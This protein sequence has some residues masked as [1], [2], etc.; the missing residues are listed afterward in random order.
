MAPRAAKLH[1]TIETAPD[2][3]TTKSQRK[4][5]ETGRYLLQVD[6]QTKGSYDTTESAQAA[7]LTIK[8]GHPV[9]QVSVYDTVECRNA[10]VELPEAAS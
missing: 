8:T 2:A 5:A 3:E 10:L 4:P 9:V 7:G 6:R 1:D